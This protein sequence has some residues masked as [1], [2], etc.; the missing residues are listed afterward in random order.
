ML[1]NTL[2]DRPDGPVV[3]TSSA[4]ALGSIPG[5]IAKIPLVSW[6]KTRTNNRSN[7]VTNS[8]L[9]KKK[10]PTLSESIEKRVL[11]YTIGEKIID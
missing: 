7:T 10:K 2:R 9:E 4:A 1:L 5:W 8:I 11:S 3:G 6:P